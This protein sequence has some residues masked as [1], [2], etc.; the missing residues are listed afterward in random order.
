MANRTALAWQNLTYDLRRLAIGVAGVGFAA[1]LMFI[2]LGF[3]NALLDSTVQIIKAMNGEVIIVSKSKYAMASVER[4]E[5][6]RLQTVK[7]V[8]GV[9]AAHPIYLEG[10]ESLLR[11]TPTRMSEAKAHRIR[12]LAYEA[13]DHVL[14][15]DGLDQ[16]RRLLRQPQTA[17]VDRQTHR[18]FKIPTRGTLDGYRGELADQ[19]VTLVGRFELGVD[20]ITDGNLIMTANNF[21]DYF[22][23]RAFGDDPLSKVDVGVVKIDG[24]RD[25]ATVKR[26][27]SRMLPED[28]DVLTKDE[29]LARE[30]H[31]WKTQAPVGYIFLVG[32]YVGFVVGVIICYQIIYADISDHMPEFATL[33][34]MGYRNVYFFQ[35]ILC[36]SFYL[37]LFGFLPGLV[38]S[39]VVYEGLGEWTG[40]MLQIKLDSIVLV[41]LTTIGMCSLSGLL[42]VRKL[43][44]ADP[45]SL[46]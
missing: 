7:G 15:I 30:I 26:A 44:T 2:E 39:Y 21:A 42:A 16:H 33:K 23:N 31:F 4:F 36:Q 24:G 17:I 27:L 32:M 38:V 35:V 10:W 3:W 34:A 5:L 46:F 11:R 1:L 12:V 41:L 9:V 13:G 37:S 6:Q 29:F 45:A 18:K 43:L 25:P 40:L 20:F 8:A 28:V 22:P 14:K 19:R